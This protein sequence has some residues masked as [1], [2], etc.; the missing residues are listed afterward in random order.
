[1][2]IVRALRE[3]FPTIQGPA[4]DNICYAT[5]NRQNAVAELAREAGIVLVVGSANSSNSQR[6]VEV[7]RSHGAAAYLIDDAESIDEVWLQDR[8]RVGLTAGA[9]APEELVKQAI[10][11]LQGLGFLRVEH[12]GS[13][14]EDVE[15]ALPPELRH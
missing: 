7:A 6:L 12:T 13:V 1:R 4:S 8:R 9:S 11:R 14:V 10:A 15:F 2:Q 5:Q 3:R